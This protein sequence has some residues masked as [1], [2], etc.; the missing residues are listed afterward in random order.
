MLAFTKRLPD[1]WIHE[2][3]APPAR[4]HRAQ[5]EGLYGRRLAVLGL[6]SIGVEIARR[7][8]AFGME[9]RGL[10]RTMRPSPLE[11]CEIVTDAFAAVDGADHV[12]IA[13]AATDETRGLVDKA[14]LDAMKPGVHLVNIARGGLV[15]EDA[16][17]GALDSGQVATASL[18][19]VTPEPLPEGHWLYAHPRVR[20]SPHISWS[21]PE[22]NELLVD[23]FRT[24][25]RRY[26]AGKP[27]DGV[28]DVQR[29]Y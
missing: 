6:G 14:L 23:T 2:P 11:G 4:W 7:A 25:L 12:V 1:S 24:N 5:L 18:D 26:L 22:S 15:D 13:A 28:V 27:L 17:H 21:M 29:G 20:L 10:R 3:P 9:V 16:L 8:L 19:A